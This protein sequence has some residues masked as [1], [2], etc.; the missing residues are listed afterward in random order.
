MIVKLTHPFIWRCPD[1]AYLLENCNKLST[2]LTRIEKQAK[3]IYP[4]EDPETEDEKRIRTNNINSYKGEAF[5]LF[6]EAVIRLF[7]CDKRVGPIKDYE[8]VTRGDIGVDGH[9]IFGNGKAGTVQ[10]KYRHSDHKLT[11]NEDHLTNFTSASMLHYKVDQNPDSN[12]KCNM[13]IFTSGDSLNFFTDQNMFG[14]MVHAVCH[15]DLRKLLDENNLF[16]EYLE[17][18]W[19]KSLE[20]AKK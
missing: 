18:S 10:C 6:I 15:Q 2:F 20:E 4:E 7:P 16:W 9:G 5:E 8:I 12:G 13:I 3:T 11:A 17:A 19:E 1:R 14:G